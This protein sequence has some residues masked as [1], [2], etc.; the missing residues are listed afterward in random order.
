M[1]DI[2]QPI[3][4]N[5]RSALLKRQRSLEQELEEL[6]KTMLTDLDRFEK[7]IPYGVTYSERITSY[8]QILNELKKTYPNA[9]WLGIDQCFSNFVDSYRDKGRRDE[10][11]MRVVIND[12]GMKIQ[13]VVESLEV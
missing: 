10:N 9:E 5:A 4:N 11:E 7:G 12:M 8:Q 3:D 2:Y 1:L 13:K 6:Q